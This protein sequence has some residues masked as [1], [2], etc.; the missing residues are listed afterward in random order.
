MFSFLTSIYVHN[1]DIA[2]AMAGSRGDRDRKPSKGHHQQ[3]QQQG[4][5][6]SQQH[7]GEPKQDQM[8]SPIRKRERAES[9]SSIESTMT[10]G[11]GGWS[12]VVCCQNVPG[13]NRKELFAL[14]PCDHIVCYECSTKMR[15]LCQQTECPICRQDIPKVRLGGEFNENR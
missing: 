14:G 15:V 13:S 9:Q 7:R 12:C 6:R 8:P 11:P 2:T 4:Q 3:P 5:S 1:F 10:N